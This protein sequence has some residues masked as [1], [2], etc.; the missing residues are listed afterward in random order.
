LSALRRRDT[1]RK[2]S[3]V[4]SIKNAFDYLRHQ[5]RLTGDEVT[6]DEFLQVVKFLTP[7]KKVN[8]QKIEILLEFLNV[9]KEH[10]IVQSAITTAV[11]FDILQSLGNDSI[12]IATIASQV[13][14]YNQGFD[15]KGMINLQQFFF[16]D[17]INLKQ[18]LSRAQ[19]SKNL[20]EFI[21]YYVQAYS[22]QAEKGYEVFRSRKI[23]LGIPGVI[24][25][26]SDRQ[27]KI[28]G[29]FDVPEVKISNKI[30]QKE[31][32]VSQIT[33]SRDL[34]QLALLGLIFQKGRGRSVYYVKM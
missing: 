4:S 26:L 34:S 16:S 25:K 21:E 12:K 23:N 20:T 19:K 24:G 33:A 13:F 29:M 2:F 14:T 18:K 10:P 1:S 28:L 3:D 32:G 7:D 27:V 30:V 17:F 15:F 22:I 5:C 31:F 8:N 6:K 9:S 11:L